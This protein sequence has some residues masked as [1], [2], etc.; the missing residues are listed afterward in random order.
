MA[1]NEY[2][3]RKKEG[4]T[5]DGGEEA[6]VGL[7]EAVADEVV[8]SCEYFLEPVERLE[9]RNDGSLIRRLRTCKAGFIYTAYNGHSTSAVS[10]KKGDYA[11]RTVHGGKHPRIHLINFL[12]QLLRVEI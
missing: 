7:G 12:P 4:G 11:R 9:E 10:S 6:D 5:H 2:M 8:F 1:V 3:H